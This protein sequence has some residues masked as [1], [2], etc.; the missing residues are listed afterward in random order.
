V[1]AAVESLERADGL[2]PRGGVE[3]ATC[4]A[5]LMDNLAGRDQDPDLQK[6]TP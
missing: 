2:L 6:E 3:L 4:N 1:V 5:L